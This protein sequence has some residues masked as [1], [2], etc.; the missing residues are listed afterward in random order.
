MTNSTG[1]SIETAVR[2]VLSNGVVALVQRNGTAPTVSVRGEIRV[3]AVFEPAEKSGLAAFTG[4]ALIRGT[5][6]HSFQDIV[7]STEAVGASVN[8]GGGVHTTGFGGKSLAEDL[9]LVLGL[10]AEMI[11]APTFPAI[12]VERLRGQFLMGLRENEQD[13]RVQASREVRSLLFPPEHP[14]SRVSSGTVDTVATIVRSDLV[15][16]HRLFHPQLTTIAV[17]GAIEPQAV[18]AQ[19]EQVFGGWRVD[20]VPREQHLPPA[21]TLAGVTRHHIEVSGKS[22]SDIVYAVHGLTRAAP[23]FYA[24]SIANMI[25]GRIG[26]GGRLGENVRERQG[27]AYYCGSSFD[28][29][30][31]AGPWA[32]LAG[33]N[34]R[35]IDTAIEAILHEIAL[36]VR[37]GPTDEEV[38]DARDFMTGSTVLGLETSDGIAG[39][40]LGIERYGLGFDYIRRYPSIIRGISHDEIV[41]AARTYLSTS[42]CVIVSAGQSN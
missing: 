12:E 27:L 29:D 42:D 28:A 23:D 22:Q 13:T 2:H 16:F 1:G 41:T 30:I 31:G 5:Q 17:V 8:A 40:L 3:G 4:A 6:H 32:A 24:A 9:P 36:F 35:D 38:A 11:G 10:L 20:G 34:P 26:M 15:A 37:E 14:Y 39:T 7:G 21:T 18:I 25:L 19:L 33:V